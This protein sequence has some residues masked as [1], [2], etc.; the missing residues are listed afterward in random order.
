MNE[1]V[2]SFSVSDYNQ[3]LPN[4]TKE[5]F[6]SDDFSDV[7]LAT[8]DD[9]QISAHKLIL[10]SF[11][12]FFKNIILK[13][14]HDKPLIYLKDIQHSELILV[15]QLIYMGQ[16]DVRNDHLE[17]FLAIANDLEILGIMDVHREFQTEEGITEETNEM[18]NTSIENE[19]KQT[20]EIQYFHDEM[21]L[22]S[23][24]G[25]QINTK[26]TNNTTF[27]QVPNSSVEKGDTNIAPY[28]YFHE[29]ETSQ[30]RI[31][32]NIQF[33]KSQTICHKCDKNFKFVGNL[34]NHINT[35]H[36]EKMKTPHLKAKTNE[37]H[38][39]S[40]SFLYPSSLNKH[41]LNTH[42]KTQNRTIY[43]CTI[44]AITKKT[45]SGIANH[46]KHKHGERECPKCDM[47]LPRVEMRKHIENKHRNRKDGG[48]KCSLCQRNFM[49][50]SGMRRHGKLCKELM[51]IFVNGK[52]KI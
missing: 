47:V 18:E 8:A 15:I 52:T 42:T 2:I 16:C 41:I 28:E 49:T 31:A 29:I 21:V 23:S 4:T 36:G 45:T 11:S 19:N 6:N 13:N 37:C 24:D 3:S 35:E 25:E 14:P 10:S 1:E 22:K 5:L 48:G 38:E 46:M 32:R 26:E 39:C 9:K 17:R 12:P 27:K 7:T 34:I 33:A 40:M 20:V 50:I 30:E 44:C 51:D 43:S